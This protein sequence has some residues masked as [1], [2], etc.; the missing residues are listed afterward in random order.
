MLLLVAHIIINTRQSVV[1]MLQQASLYYCAVLLPILIWLSGYLGC[2]KFFQ[3]YQALFVKRGL[4][5]LRCPAI[6]ILQFVLPFIIM[7]L[8]SAIQ[9]YHSTWVSP[10][11]TFNDLSR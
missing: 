6:T 3:Q 7:V 4:Y 5:V 8:V 9:R 1:T 10:P 2:R 11:M